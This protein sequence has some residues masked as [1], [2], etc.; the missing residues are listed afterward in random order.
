MDKHSIPQISSTY[1]VSRQPPDE[2]NEEGLP[3]AILWI[4]WTPIA[5]EGGLCTANSV[6]I[7]KLDSRSSRRSMAEWKRLKP[8]PN[9]IS[10]GSAKASPRQRYFLKFES[11]NDLRQVR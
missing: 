9:L 7:S 8:F 4:W 5:G 6:D 1:V 3:E 11:P 10:L 2:D